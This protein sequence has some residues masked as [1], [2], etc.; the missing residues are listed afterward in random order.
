[1]ISNKL[2]V[3]TDAWILTHTPPPP[4]FPPHTPYVDQMYILDTRVQQ[5]LIVS[6]TATKVM[7]IDRTARCFKAVAKNVNIAT[8]KHYLLCDWCVSHTLLYFESKLYMCVHTVFKPSLLL[9]SLIYLCNLYMLHTQLLP[10][11]MFSTLSKFNIIYKLSTSVVTMIGLY[12]PNN[13]LHEKSEESYNFPQFD[14][15]FNSWT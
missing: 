6:D 10:R 5:W 9:P 7:S 8:P 3:N 1:M 2:Y 11:T 13:W 12:V 4:P 15:S 14:I